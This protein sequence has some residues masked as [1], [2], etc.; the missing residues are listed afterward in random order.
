MKDGGLSVATLA[1]ASLSSLAAALFVHK[2]WQGGAIFAAAVTPVIVAIVSE[3]LR[4]PVTR[5]EALREERRDRTRRGRE[6]FGPPSPADEPR[7]DP[8]GIWGEDRA[9]RR[10]LFGTRLTP[11]HLKIALA[12]GIAAFALVTVG[13]TALE[14]VG[15]GSAGGDSRTTIFGGKDRDADREQ[16]DTD[17][18]QPAATETQP[19]EIP[20]TTPSEEEQPVEP[21]TVTE[22]PAEE[23][24]PQET[25]PAAPA[26]APA[27]P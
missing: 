8:F 10:G 12:T 20:E 11:R 23:T 4:K 7:E 15:G 6:T 18:E 25:T 21:G 2:F 27:A 16:R 22:P 13:L 26:P 17:A 9:S 14:L 5:F 1:I 19:E 24:V 3:T